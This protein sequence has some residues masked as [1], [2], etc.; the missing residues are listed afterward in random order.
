MSIAWC[1]QD[2][3]LLVSCG[4]DNR[5]IAWNPN[6][7]EPNGEILSEI[8]KTNQW[9]FDIQ[10]C[11]RNPAIIACPSFDGHVSVYSL[12]GGKTQQIQTTNKIAD[13]F[14]GMDGYVQAPVP[15][16]STAPTSVD[17]SKAPKWLKRPVGAKF[18]VRKKNC[19]LLLE[20]HKTAIVEV[21]PLEHSSLR[22]S[23]PKV[24]QHVS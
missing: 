15:Q 18:G 2:P 8:A 11:P 10:W 17:L 5:I 20:L 3:D 4:K 19:T 24:R 21:V 7:N 1:S 14:P 9:N 13:S 6:S 22:S 23:C 12:M 16:Q